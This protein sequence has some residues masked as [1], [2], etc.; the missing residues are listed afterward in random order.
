[1]RWILGLVGTGIDGPSISVNIMEFNRPDSLED[2]TNLGLTLDEGSSCWRSSS[3]RS[4]PRK[5][6]PTRYCGRPVV[7]ATA[8]AM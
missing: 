6:A 5:S 8:G 3:R 2:I 7:P 1:M 4:S